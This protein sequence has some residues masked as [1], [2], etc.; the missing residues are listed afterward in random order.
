MIQSLRQRNSSGRGCSIGPPLKNR[1][2]VACCRCH[3][4]KVRCDVALRGSP[5]TNCSLDKVDCLVP[6]TRRRKS[7]L[8]VE[9][10]SQVGSLV[11]STLKRSHL[12]TDTHDLPRM[13]FGS[14]FLSTSHN[15]FYSEISSSGGAG[16]PF[17][18]T[19]MQTLPDQYASE[20]TCC[21]LK[22]QAIA[23]SGPSGKNTPQRSVTLPNYIRELPTT[24]SKVDI[25]YLIS[26]GVLLIPELTLRN[27]LLRAYVHYVHPYIPILDIEDFLQTIL[28]GDRNRR[29]S[30]L[31]FQSVMFAGSAFADLKILQAAGFETNRVARKKFF[32]RAQLLYNFDYETDQITIVQSLLL[33][34]YYYDAPGHQKDSWHWM[35]VVLSLAH[36]IG[37]NRDPITLGMDL[38]RQRMWKRIWWSIYVRDRLIALG[39]RRP[40]YA[41]DEDSNVPVLSLDDFELQ[42]CSPNIIKLFGGSNI[43]ENCGARRE[44]ALMFI[45]KTKLCILLGYI[46]STQYFTVR[47]ESGMPTETMMLSPK[48]STAGEGKLFHLNLLLEN[49]LSYLPTEAHFTP[50]GHSK[51]SDVQQVLHLHRAILKMIYHTAS[52]A[53]HRPQLTSITPPTSSH[54]KFQEISA[55][56]VF[57]AAMEVTDI[58]LEM[59]SLGLTSNYPPIGVTVLMPAAMVHLLKIRSDNRG[60]RIAS[61]QRLCQC[62]RILNSLRDV[63]AVADFAC[64]ILKAAIQKSGVRI[65]AAEEDAHSSSLRDRFNDDDLPDTVRCS[66][67]PKLQSSPLGQSIPAPRHLEEAPVPDENKESLSCLMNLPTDCQTL[68]DVFDDL[69]KFDEDWIHDPASG[70]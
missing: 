70:Q 54:S 67:T 30:L 56:K 41:I 1:A 16:R 9:N 37:L 11:S 8:K 62:I 34:S 39:T 45:E 5:C 15:T 49:W 2:S 38:K 4:R 46:L 53:L 60:V 10:I 52:S 42:C 35:G 14:A 6:Q 66:P 31:L 28:E 55:C 43:L 64:T 57:H 24:L 29:I 68:H 36:T 48:S 58:A 61:S 27:E 19:E 65:T 18:T 32:D 12:P 50:L 22:N 51:L 3:S 69:I 33:M 47:Y 21:T 59:D 20:Y 25:D 17:D 13:A 44:L 40:I 23:D 26:K 7:Y 63:Y